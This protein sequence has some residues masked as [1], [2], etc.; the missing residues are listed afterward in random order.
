MCLSKHSKLSYRQPQAGICKLAVAKCCCRHGS[1]CRG[2][3]CP[4]MVTFC[5]QVRTMPLHE[6]SRGYQTCTQGRGMSPH[7]SLGDGEQAGSWSPGLLIT[8]YFERRR[9]G[10]GDE[11]LPPSPASCTFNEAGSG[12]DTCAL[13]RG[14]LS[15]ELLPA[16]SEGRLMGFL[17]VLH[18]AEVWSAWFCFILGQPGQSLPRT[19]GA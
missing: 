7:E 10:E 15:A 5:R 14:R 12:A 6:Q 3:G 2:S 19:G 9:A 17:A 11:V 8:N 18:G 1:P 13:E 4:G 16:I